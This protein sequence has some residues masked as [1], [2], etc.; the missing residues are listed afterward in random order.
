[1]I[2][3]KRQ[4]PTWGKRVRYRLEVWLSQGVA[5]LAQL[6]PRRVVQLVGRALGALAYYLTPGLQKIAMQNLD[7]A[8][9][10]SRSVADKRRIARA[11]LQHF[12]GT[13]ATLLWSP[14]LTPN[15]FRRYVE[16]NET[17]IP[18]GCAV[19]FVTMHYGD[20]ELL[21]L[22][23]SYLGSPLTIVQENMRN[24]LLENFFGRLRSHTGHKLVAQELAAMRI[25]RALREGGGTALLID[26]STNRRGGGIWLDFFGLEAFSSPAFAALALR[27]GAPVVPAYAQPLADGRARLVYGPAIEFTPTGDVERDIRELSQRCLKFCEDVIRAAPEPWLWAYKRWSP[28]PTVDRGRYPEYSRYVAMRKLRRGGE[29]AK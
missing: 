3:S 21:G 1:M 27:S 29:S 6:F 17:T 7:I 25:F 9:G 26:T 23:E 28:R 8:F 11:S 20:W 4:P 12:A 13:I 22:T 18:R 15:N 10:D 24:E 19:V 2:R 14:R 5:A 16:V